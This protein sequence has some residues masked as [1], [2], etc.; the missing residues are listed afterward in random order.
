MDKREKTLVWTLALLIL[1]YLLI[2][3][4]GFFGFKDYKAC[5]GNPFTYGAEKISSDATGDL[6]C[7]CTFSNPKYAPFYFNEEEVAVLLDG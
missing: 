1:G 3:Y 7:T 5:S 4:V 6:F 2:G